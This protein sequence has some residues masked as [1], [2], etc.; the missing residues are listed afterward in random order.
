MKNILQL[1]KYFSQLI[2]NFGKWHNRMQNVTVTGTDSTGIVMGL[3]PSKIYL[4]R[5]LA[6]N[7]IGRS[8]PSKPVEALTQ[9]EG[10]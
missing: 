3:K 6:E 7:R 8:E 9:E 1:A 10:K 2:D 4:F 5:V